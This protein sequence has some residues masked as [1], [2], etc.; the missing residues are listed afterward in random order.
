MRRPQ[1]HAALPQRVGCVLVDWDGTLADTVPLVRRATNIVL[2]RRGFTPVSLRQ[3]HEGM[4]LPTTERMVFH[5]GLRPEDAAEADTL[6]EISGEFFSVL[7]S[8]EAGAV[9]PFPGI[10][11]L[12]EWITRR[13]VPVG[14][15]T[16]NRTEAVRVHADQA[17]LSSFLRC[18]VSEDEVTAP[19]PDPEGIRL[20]MNTLGCEPHET[21]YIGDAPTDA[22]AGRAANV[23]TILAGWAQVDGQPLDGAGFDL[24]YDTPEELI[25]ALA[26]RVH[27][28]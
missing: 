28:P 10:L 19:K 4:R 8:R 1:S 24:R 5:T 17:G 27:R 3:V 11:E 2:E 14:V 22:A 26:N 25:R 6:G 15:V 9:T 12:L 13:G 7:A 23:V 16:N 20:A 18:Y 21:V